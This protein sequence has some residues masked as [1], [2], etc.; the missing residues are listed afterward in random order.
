MANE[1][2]KKAP[3]TEKRPVHDNSRHEDKGKQQQGGHKQ[4]RKGHEKSTK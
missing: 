2:T 1:G 4:D 3:D